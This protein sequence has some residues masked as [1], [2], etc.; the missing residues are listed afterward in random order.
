MREGVL[1]AR[2]TIEMQG[3]LLAVEEKYRSTES[4]EGMGGAYGT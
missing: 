2:E 4:P 1:G 3:N